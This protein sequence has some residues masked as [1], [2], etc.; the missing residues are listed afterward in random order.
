MEMLSHF[1]SELEIYIIHHS[2]SI[3][4]RL[5]QR[6]AYGAILRYPTPRGQFSIFKRKLDIFIKGVYFAGHLIIPRS[7][8]PKHTCVVKYRS[9]FI[10]V[11]SHAKLFDVIFD[12]LSNFL[13]SLLLGHFLTLNLSSN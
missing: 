9:Y 5:G 4:L 11:H 3:I 8:V 12:A 7:R 2:H 10:V 6:D 1:N 13:H